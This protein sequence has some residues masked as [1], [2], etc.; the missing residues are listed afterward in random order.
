MSIISKTRLTRITEGPC[1]SVIMLRTVSPSNTEAVRIENA[2]QLFNRVIAL[3]FLA[4][5]EISLPKG[6]SGEQCLLTQSSG[7]LLISVLLRV[8]SSVF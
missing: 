7:R 1:P 2:F 6:S 8:N 3:C 4:I 5:D